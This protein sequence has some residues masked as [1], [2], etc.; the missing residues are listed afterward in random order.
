MSV[1]RD[2]EDK[3]TTQVPVRSSRYGRPSVSSKTK[4]WGVYWQENLQYLR[5]YICMQ[6]F[7][8]Y[9]LWEPTIPPRPPP[10][11][12]FFYLT[13]YNI[14]KNYS[15]CFFKNSNASSKSTLSNSGPSI[16]TVVVC[17]HFHLII[18]FIVMTYPF[19]WA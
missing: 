2:E 5:C 15:L 13:E 8:Q 1:I 16:A 9:R 12:N 7:I 11:P 4:V 10:P 19:S 6:G 3:D 17:V 14:M 18:C